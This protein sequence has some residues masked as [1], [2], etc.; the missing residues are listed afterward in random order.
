MIGDNWQLRNVWRHLTDER[1]ATGKEGL[2][3]T[4]KRLPTS[5]SSL[6]TTKKSMPTILESLATTEE[7]LKATKESGDNWEQINGKRRIVTN[8]KHS[9][10]GRTIII[11]TKTI[12]W[13][14]YVQFKQQIFSWDRILK[15]GLS[16]GELASPKIHTLWKI[17]VNR[18]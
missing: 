3:T 1:L 8:P 6:A 9:F 15:N 14:G 11:V 16:F 5:E 12:I 17:G 7:Y 2:T 4:K 13:G 18:S 10:C